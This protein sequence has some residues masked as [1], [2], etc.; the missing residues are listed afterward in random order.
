MKVESN[1]TARADWCSERGRTGPVEGSRYIVVEGV[2]GV[3]KSSL[4]RLLAD[5]LGGDS[6]HEPVF[7]NPFLSMFSFLLL[8]G[9]LY[10]YL[11][12]F[13]FWSL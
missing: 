13:F 7:E 6:V 4:T 1:P 11:I 12:I 5:K 8:F 9:D 10:I 2:I 3:G